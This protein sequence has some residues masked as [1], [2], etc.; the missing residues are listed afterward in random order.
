[1]SASLVLYSIAVVLLTASLVNITVASDLILF[2]KIEKNNWQRLN[3]PR[4]TFAL[5]GTAETKSVLLVFQYK[6]VNSEILFVFQVL[7][8]VG[9]QVNTY[10]FCFFLAKP[11]SSFRS[12]GSNLS[13]FSL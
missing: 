5:K 11:I 6:C 4:K 7:F 10:E 12:F 9:R 1:M 3:C 13:F 8:Y 2:T